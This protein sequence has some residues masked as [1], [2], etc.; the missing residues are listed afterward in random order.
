MSLNFSL[1]SSRSKNLFEYPNLSIWYS[2]CYFFIEK[3]T[4]SSVVNFREPKFS[5]T[6]IAVIFETRLKVKV[7]TVLHVKKKI[8]TN[9]SC[10]PK[11]HITPML[12]SLAA[13]LFTP[14][15]HELAQLLAS[16]TLTIGVAYD[17]DSR[18]HRH[19]YTMGNLC[20]AH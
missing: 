1:V 15:E 3:F 10:E 5:K 14:L 17:Q 18:G 6:E 2:T 13:R 16:Q 7:C 12:R 9:L 20:Q 4:T 11:I 8:V 19:N